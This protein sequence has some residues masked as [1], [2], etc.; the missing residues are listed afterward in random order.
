MKNLE[1]VVAV[2]LGIWIV[3]IL[4]YMAREIVLIHQA[5]RSSNITEVAVSTLDTVGRHGI[6]GHK[7]ELMV[8]STLNGRQGLHTDTCMSSKYE[9]FSTAQQ[10]AGSKKRLQLDSSSTSIK[11]SKFDTAYSTLT[12]YKVIDK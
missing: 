11:I 3:V 5:R 6:I 9:A 2:I 12:V 8:W 7:A 10:M 1:K 4:V